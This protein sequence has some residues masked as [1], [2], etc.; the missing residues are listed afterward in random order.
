MGY[1]GP[2]DFLPAARLDKTVR[3]DRAYYT[4]IWSPLRKADRYDIQKTVP[5]MAGLYELYYRDDG[6]SC[7]LFHYGRAWLGGLRAVIREFTD[8]DL[9][10]DRPDIRDILKARPCYYRFTVCESREDMEDILYY[11]AG[12]RRK[13]ADTVRVSSGRYGEI[14]VKQAKIGR[15]HV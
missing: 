9:M 14:R 1:Y 5:A 13:G 10:K 11:F 6:N 3:D 2:M 7:H 15:A 4:I 8:P 12:F